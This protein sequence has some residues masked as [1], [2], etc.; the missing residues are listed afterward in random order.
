MSILSIQDS[1]ESTKSFSEQLAQ[2][3]Q[4]QVY[5]TRSKMN[6]MNT[7]LTEIDTLDVKNIIFSDPV[8]STIDGKPPI[9]YKRI[10]ISIK[11]PD[12]TTG[13]LIC[14][15]T[16]CFS[17]GVS[18]NQSLETKEV[19]GYSLPI[20]LYSRD[21]ASSEEKQ[22]VESFNAIIEHI[23]T[24]ILAHK[25]DI[26]KYDLESSDL[27]KFNP[28]YWK[29]DKGKIVEDAGPVLYA[30]LIMGK[31]EIKSMMFDPE[32]NKLN[33]MD[34]IGK[35]CR[36][37]VAVKFESIYIGAKLSMQI[38]VHEATV[39]V[40]DYG[41]SKRLLSRP[42]GEIK[43]SAA[44]ITISVGAPPMGAEGDDDDAGSIDGESTAAAAAPAPPAPAAA[45]TIKVV[46]RAPPAA[47][48]K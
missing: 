47:A 39:E 24:H 14:K 28:L 15:T 16:K 19:S 34:L 33:P 11:N 22:W 29:R 35:R 32:D 21:G 41:N 31:G 44:P 6:S 3:A 46:K 25:D 23:K 20:C 10:M 26:E 18:E 48:K 45:K 13:D 27:K 4:K 2:E 12:G 42:G 9:N 1:R 5:L 30:K 37:E 36:V 40:L 38:K 17:F 8:H 7:Q 43:V